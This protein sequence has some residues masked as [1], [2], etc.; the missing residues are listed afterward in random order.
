[1]KNIFICYLSRVDL[2]I[3]HAINQL[4]GQSRFIDLVVSRLES[5]Q[6]K[7]LLFIGT[8][9]ALWFQ[10]AN[11]QVRR[12]ETLILLLIAIVL[13]LIM[14][15]IFADLFPFRQRPM[16]ASGIGYRTPVFAMDAYFENW[17]A[18]PSDTAAIV[19]AMTTGFWLLSRWWGLLWVSFSMTAIVARIYFG[20]HYPGDALA[21]ALIGVLVTLAIDN[22]LMHERIAKPIVAWEQRAPALFYGFLFPFLLEISTLFSFMRGIYHAISQVVGG[23]VK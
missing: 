14:A 1:M 10:R 16:F 3:F 12:R 19:F 22:E 13:S 21:G 11:A 23:L 2:V 6:L 15:R 18:F 20:L 5:A 9:A 8:F 7:G 4:C 17:S